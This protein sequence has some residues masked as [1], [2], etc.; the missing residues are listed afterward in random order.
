MKTTRDFKRFISE[1][2]IG[3]FIVS[4]LNPVPAITY[5][6]SDKI[7]YPLKEISKLECRFNNFQ[8]LDSDCKQ[9]LPILNTS[10]Y[11]KYAKL[12]WW[13]NDF[14]RLYTVLWWASYKYW[15]D[16]WNWWHIWTDI[17]TA[18]WTPVYSIANWKVIKAKE[19][20]MLWKFVT[21]EHE[22][23]W[24]KIFST[25]AHLSKLEVS[26]GQS[27]NVW[28]KIWE[29]WSTW[30][31]TGNH[32][33]MQ[34]DLDT[35][36]S[37]PYY[38]D[39]NACPFN[40]YKITEEG[41]CFNELTKNSIDP[42]L[43]FE[44]QWA[45]L[46]NISTKNINIIDKN[47][48]NNYEENELDIFDKTVY[49]WYAESDI[50]KVQEI[51]QKIWVYRWDINWKYEDIE[52]SIIQYQISNNLILNENDYWAGWFWPKTRYTAK[53]D[54]LKYLEDWIQ[55]DS[56]KEYD[57]T[58][59]E[60]QKISKNDLMTREEI[61]KREVEQ[62][63][64]YNN[65]ELYFENTWWNIAKWWTE[66]IKLKITDRK[67]NLFKWIMPWSMT[68][69][70]NTE[71]VD[72][73]PKKLFYFTDWKRDIKVTWLSTWNTILYI[74]IWNETIKTMSLNVYNPKVNIYPETS[75]IISSKKT[76]LWA[77]QP[78]VV[79][80]KDSNDK[81]LINLRYGSTFNIK[82]SWDNKICI[83][84]W[85]IK[86]IKNI[87]TKTCNDNEFKN[88]FNFTYDDTVWWLLLFDYIALSK[89][90][91]VTIKNNYNNELL[92]ERS[93][94]VW[95]PKWLTNNYEYKN[96]VI[97]MIEKWISTWLNSWYFLEN[98]WL[99]ELDALVWVENALKLIK[100]KTDE[101]TKEIIDKNLNDINK[102]KQKANKFKTITRLDFL[103]LNYKYLV[104]DKNIN[105][106]KNYK[107]LD[108]DTNQ[109][110]TRIFDDNITWKD[111]FWKNYFQP[112]TTITRWEW[113]FLIS[114]TL[115][116]NAQTYL[117]L[118]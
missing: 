72:I 116:K 108:L 8:D 37:H 29:V 19:D 106:S 99:T 36:I 56:I 91:N 90:F 111:Q 17:A 88:E 68:F 6:S 42:L 82:A 13:Y 95:D 112:I 76:I 7:I 69:I 114:K 5:A 46:D 101:Q 14:T 71:K 75:K 43:F 3:I 100:T 52:E 80:F 1:L 73:F 49:I 47:T 48:N 118:K 83:K 113:A 74:K 32:L 28:K 51:F 55:T 50:K 38:Y 87:Y 79:A 60:T 81:Y 94:I 10:D 67:G 25:Y 70:V 62:F 4:T 11:S 110:L 97:K 63:L 92:A 30:N 104:L 39:Y 78:W 89:D 20:L 102:E 9:E 33:H 31:S 61:E 64:K 16:V 65:I 105:S 84:Q 22:I 24:K 35:T 27:I 57:T 103:N 40:Y 2:T 96:E 93:I 15:W 45:I 98:R 115:E 18:K 12:N 117:T 34:I 41:V 21:I 107:D 54:Y 23:K 58:K 26:V 86:D 85:N 66:T 109:K 59:I 77:K 53:K 44:T